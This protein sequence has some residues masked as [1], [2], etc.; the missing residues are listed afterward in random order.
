VLLAAVGIGLMVLVALPRFGALEEPANAA[1]H[2]YTTSTG[3]LL[4][5]L[6]VDMREYLHLTEHYAGDAAA[7]DLAPFTNR[8]G[9]PWLA[10]HLPWEAPISLNVVVLVFLAVGL[11]ALLATLHRLGCALGP[12]AAVAMV[13]SVSFPVFYWGSFNYV[14]GAVV[15][16]L[17][18]LMAALTYRRLVPA[19]VT[20]AGGLLIKESMLVAVPVVAVWVHLGGG[21]LR[22][23]AAAY[24][25][26]GA[27]ALAGVLGARLLGPSAERFYNPWFP[28]PREMHH[29]AGA[30][31][32]RTG[33][34]GQVFLTGVLPLAL[35]Y[36]AW[37]RQR[38]GELGLER[39]VFWMLTTGVLAGVLLNFHA[40]IAAQ[41]DGRTLW[42]VYPFA[43]ALGAAVLSPS[44]RLDETAAVPMAATDD[45]R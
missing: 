13:W 25:A 39:R 5:G 1:S 28:T 19:L 17:A 30:N 3:R 43:L 6:T 40:L 26:T 18:V 44:I 2:S 9:V 31:I 8:I 34:I 42:T 38:G 24:S 12:I 27:V 29:Y 22:R 7:P 21:P 16:L 4:P 11:V 45:L 33:P 41:W 35:A 36:L 15:G 23:R 20:L 14:D 37:R 32:G 10:G